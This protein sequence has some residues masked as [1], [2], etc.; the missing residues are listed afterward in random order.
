[1]FGTAIGKLKK[2]GE[3]GKYKR[4]VVDMK[5]KGK[6]SKLSIRIPDEID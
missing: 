1:M 4:Y 3:R 5:I 2:K 6:Q